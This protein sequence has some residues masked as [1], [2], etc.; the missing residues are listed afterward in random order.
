MKEPLKIELIKLLLSAIVGAGLLLLG[1]IG[2]QLLPFYEE[3]KKTISKDLLAISAAVFCLLFV[4]CLIAL[5]HLTAKKIKYGI[6][7]D[8]KKNPYCPAC[9]TPINRIFPRNNIY[10]ATCKKCKTAIQLNRETDKYDTV[11]ELIDS[12]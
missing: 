1:Q 8:K 7:W 4:A 5:R 9:K 11:E 10:N 12:I 3:L 2:L 6:F